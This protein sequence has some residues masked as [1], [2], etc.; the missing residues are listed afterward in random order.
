[1]PYRMCTDRPDMSKRSMR[2][3]GERQLGMG[4][5]GMWRAVV[6]GCGARLAGGRLRSGMVGGVCVVPIRMHEHAGAPST[7]II[8]QNTKTSAR[9]DG[10]GE[11]FLVFSALDE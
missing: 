10:V 11:A 7:Q 5:T 9:R 1:M 2:V 3:G 6:C 4:M 8:H